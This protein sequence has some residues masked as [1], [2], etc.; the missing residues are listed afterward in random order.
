M[1]FQL[2]RFFL[3]KSL[4]FQMQSEL[5]ERL[6]DFTTGNAKK[7]GTFDSLQ[8][9]LDWFDEQ[10]LDWR[11]AT[12]DKSRQREPQKWNIPRLPDKDE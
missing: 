9:I 8:K 10:R 7:H 12:Y 1:H 4:I 11:N 2:L 6:W 3:N 5:S